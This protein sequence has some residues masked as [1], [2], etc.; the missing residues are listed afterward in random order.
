MKFGISLLYLFGCLRTSCKT[1]IFKCFIACKFALVA[2]F[3]FLT[4]CS[5]MRGE[6][7]DHEYPE[8]IPIAV[9]CSNISAFIL[10]I[11]FVWLCVYYFIFLPMNLLHASKPALLEYDDGMLRPRCSLFRNFRQYENLHMLFWISKD[12]AWNRLNLPM[13]LLCLV[14]TVAIS[15][16]LLVISLTSTHNEVSNC[17]FSSSSSSSFL[18]VLLC[19][20]LC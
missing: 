9:E 4:C 16:D 3:L 17:L 8:E 13:W 5:W 1:F 2:K 20:C 10:S 12:L 15:A 18:R 19:C 11:A 6:A 7:H 14:P